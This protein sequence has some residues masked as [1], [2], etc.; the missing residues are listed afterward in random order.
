MSCMK[1]N[2]VNQS[3]YAS[4]GDK[5]I[6][7]INNLQDELQSSNGKKVVLVAYEKE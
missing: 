4:I 3:K 5:D 2:Q 7:T 1:Q 6:F